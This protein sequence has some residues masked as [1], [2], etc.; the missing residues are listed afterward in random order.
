MATIEATLK[1]VKEAGFRVIMASEFDQDYWIVNLAKSRRADTKDWKTGR[2]TTL[3][4]ALVAALERA[5]PRS[6]AKVATNAAELAAVEVDPFED[7][8]G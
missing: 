4:E 3:A 7:I 8:L 2:G 5:V 1:A 6:K